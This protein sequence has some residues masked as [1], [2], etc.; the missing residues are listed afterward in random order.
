MHYVCTIQN[1]KGQK[2]LTELAPDPY[3]SI[4]KVHLINIDVSAKSDE[5]PSLPYQDIKEKPKRMYTRMDECE[6][7]I[8]PPKTQFTGV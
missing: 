3:F 8:P 2:L 7:S 6:N 1:N 5:F 4:I